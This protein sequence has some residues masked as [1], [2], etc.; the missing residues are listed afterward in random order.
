MSSLTTN[1]REPLEVLKTYP[2]FQALRAKAETWELTSRPKE[3]KRLKAAGTFDEIIDSRAESCWN[4]VADCQR[5]GMNL[6]EAQ[7]VAY[8]NIYLPSE[9]GY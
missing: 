3:A 5:A 4:A 1:P 6:I 2:A 9:K 7:E 8:P